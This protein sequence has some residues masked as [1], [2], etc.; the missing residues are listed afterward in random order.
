M[1]SLS[2]S[3]EFLVMTKSSYPP[4]LLLDRRQVFYH[5]SLVATVC[6]AVKG[7]A[8]HYDIG[9][10]KARTVKGRE[11]VPPYSITYPNVGM[12]F[13]KEL[14]FFRQFSKIDKTS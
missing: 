14:S 12:A 2:V 8:Q 13:F 3:V 6:E 10:R 9:R 5:L 7:V 4:S 1:C 11:P